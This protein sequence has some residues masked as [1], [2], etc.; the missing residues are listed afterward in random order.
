MYKKIQYSWFFV[1]FFSKKSIKFPYVR[2]LKKFYFS[3]ICQKMMFKIPIYTILNFCFQKCNF[4]I[5]QKLSTLFFKLTLCME[6]NDFFCI[7]SFIFTM[8]DK[9]KFHFFQSFLPYFRVTPPPHSVAEKTS[10][11]VKILHIVFSTKTRKSVI[12]RRKWFFQNFRKKCTYGDFDENFQTFA[13]RLGVMW[14][15]WLQKSFQTCWEVFRPWR[16]YMRALML[17]FQKIWNWN[18]GIKKSGY[19]VFDVL[20]K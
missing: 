17:I 12:T 5:L 18:F 4:T 9:S 19:W 15:K 7:F 20:S 10:K 11:S 2:F 6:K 14:L 1:V 13:G 16:A 8:V 3:K